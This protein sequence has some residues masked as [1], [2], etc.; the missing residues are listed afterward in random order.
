MVAGWQGV[1][2]LGAK[3]EGIRKFKLAV[4]KQSRGYKALNFLD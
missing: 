4:T 1:G 3:G 2:G